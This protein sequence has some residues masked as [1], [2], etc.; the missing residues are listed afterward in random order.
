VWHIPSTQNSRPI[1]QGTLGCS[2]ETW[3]CWSIPQTTI[4]DT[5]LISPL[6][7]IATIIIIYRKPFRITKQ[8]LQITKD[9]FQAFLNGDTQIA[10][11]EAFINSIKLYAETF[12]KSERCAKMVQ[13]G[14]CSN[15]DFKEIFRKLVEKRVSSIFVNYWP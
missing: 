12:L 1:W 8:Q 9:R 15:N 7:S 11:D 2:K 13:S 14:G 6:L 5:G 3:E 10:A 4:H